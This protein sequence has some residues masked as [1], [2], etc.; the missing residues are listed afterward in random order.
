MNALKFL[1]LFSNGFVVVVVFAV[2]VLV[3]VVALVAVDVVLVAGVI[4]LKRP[5]V[6]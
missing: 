1:G 5:S 2:V 3:A 6:T 4:C